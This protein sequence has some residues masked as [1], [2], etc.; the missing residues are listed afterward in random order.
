LFSVCCGRGT[1]TSGEVGTLTP[2]LRVSATTPTISIG[3]DGRSAGPIVRRRPIALVRAKKRAAN[4]W[5]TM[6]TGGASARS[7]LVNPRPE[8]SGTPS[9]LKCAA[10]AAVTIVVGS[11]APGASTPPMRNGAVKGP[12]GGNW[13][14]TETARMPGTCSIRAIN[15]SKNVL[16]A[17][18]RYFSSGTVSRIV[19]TLRTSKPGSTWRMFAKLRMSSPAPSRSITDSAIS[20]TMSAWRNTR[21]PRP[22]VRLRPSALSASCGSV[23]VEWS[24]GTRATSAAEPIVNRAAQASTRPFKDAVSPNDSSRSGTARR[25]ARTPIS[26]KS[27][28]RAA[29]AAASTAISL[30]SSRAIRL[31]R[32]PSARRTATSR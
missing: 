10:L 2:W 19:S 23:F 25:A 31:R 3:G 9:V 27:K 5:L 8:T 12:D 22:P 11:V 24:M 29:P 14:A 18:P 6:T 13:L 30:R 15:C 28:P 7:A 32:A 21:G 16:I 4:A 1:N 17:A 20:A 26:A